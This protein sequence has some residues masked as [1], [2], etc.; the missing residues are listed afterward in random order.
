MSYRVTIPDESYY[1]RLVKCQDACPVGTDA[2]GYVRAIAAGDYERAYLIARGPNPLASICGRVCGAPCEANCRRGSLDEP[3]AI[4]ALKRTA[5]ERFGPE[6][7][8]I[9][10]LELLRR[11]LQDPRAGH[12]GEGEE[13]LR[14]LCARLGG[15]DP[16]E[17]PRSGRR[18]AIIG[19]GP[20]G[21]A[22]AHDL[23]LLG[24]G[25]NIFEMEEEPAGMLFHG[26]PEYRLPRDLLRAEIEV[27]RA[28]GVEFRC[29]TR[30]GEDVGFDELL[31]SFDAVVIAVGAKS[32][33][34]LPLPGVQGPGVLGGVEFLRD[35]SKKQPVPELGSRVVVIG[36]G[37][38]AYDVARTVVRQIGVDTAR[39]ALRQE[40]VKQ[41]TLVSLES[42]EEMPADDEEILAGDEEG[43]QRL[44]SLGPV[45]IER[46]EHGRVTGVIFQK[47]LRVFD[48]GGRFAPLFD[49][50][51]LTT[52]PCDTVIFAIGQALDVSFIDPERDGV[53]LTE[54]GFIA[55]DLDTLATSRPEVFVAGDVAYGPRLLIHAVASGKKAARSVHRYLTGEE[56]TPRLAFAYEVLEDYRR[57][58]GYEALHHRA[59][60]PLRPVAERLRGVDVPIEAMLDDETAR[61]EASRCLDCAVNPVFDGT[62]CL[63]C[64][65]CVEVCP[66]SCLKIVSFERLEGGPELEALRRAWQQEEGET[67]SAILKDEE[68]CI[69]CGLCARRCPNA[70]ITMERF[71]FQVESA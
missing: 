65:G 30:V 43:V 60:P 32:S 66:E 42:L 8:R 20:A 46:D 44:N 49:E 15:F 31:Q 61:R 36:G 14:P 4:R 6:S 13:E 40:G 50:T 56:V 69:R 25:S 55:C 67:L 16:E 45:R 11:L 63:L 33:R 23:A 3:V 68:A 39:T 27:I 28:L 22:C 2:R 12:E 51:V 9:R 58:A 29:N 57:E 10:P 1:R 52:V 64:G 7:G 41:V 26:I 53:K 19:S 35:V 5:T 48:E 62:R 21:L 17:L 71:C 34:T 38:V 37:N 54:R 59:H 47:C 18:V 70:A 24:H